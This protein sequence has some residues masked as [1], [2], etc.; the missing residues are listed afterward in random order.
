MRDA[1]IWIKRMDKC[2]SVAGSTSLSRLENPSF[3]VFL[4]LMLCIL[5]FCLAFH[6]RLYLQEKLCANC[7]GQGGRFGIATF[8]LDQS[9]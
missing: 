9:I 5:L 2:K 7:V 4:L 8:V 3:P 1:A 6:V